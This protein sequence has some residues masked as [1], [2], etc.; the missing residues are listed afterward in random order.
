MIHKIIKEA[1]YNEIVNQIF[2]LNVLCT[3][4]KIQW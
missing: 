2:S 1:N 4:N 3:F